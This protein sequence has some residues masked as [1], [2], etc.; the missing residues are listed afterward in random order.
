MA[1]KYG[2][3]LVNAKMNVIETTVGTGPSLLLLTGAAPANCA[4][5]T[6]GST[7]CTITLPSDWAGAASGGT[8]AKNGTWSGTATGTGTVGYFR[9]FDSGGGTCHIQGSV[10]AGSGDLSL[11]N[12]V[13]NTSQVVT[14]SS[15]N[16]IG[17][18][19]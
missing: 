1:L 5:A 14:I 11:D 3:V 12:N 2:A 17:Q 15:F 16:L 9:V 8:V 7:V 13:I 4:A 18:N 19:L 10:G 6:T